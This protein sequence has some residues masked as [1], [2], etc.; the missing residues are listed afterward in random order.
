MIDRVVRREIDGPELRI[1]SDEAPHRGDQLWLVVEQ[2]RCRDIAAAEDDVYATVGPLSPLV[3]IG[4]QK[5]RCGGHVA[6]ARD[7]AVTP[8]QAH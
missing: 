2:R 4:I 8:L 7:C 3:C 5:V 1:M 6:A